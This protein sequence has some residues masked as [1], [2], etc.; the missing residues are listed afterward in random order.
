MLWDRL[1]VVLGRSWIL[2]ASPEVVLDRSWGGLGPSWALLGWSWEAPGVPWEAPGVPLG[3]PK[4]INK[5]IR[6]SIRNRAE[7]ELHRCGP[8]T[9]P[10]V[11]SV[12]L[13]GQR[14]SDP[15]TLKSY[16]NRYRYD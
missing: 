15:V 2:L 9:T 8:N 7:I 6:K 12:F 11:V 1:G 13:Q 14:K 16:Q 5:L 4:S 10:V 3:G